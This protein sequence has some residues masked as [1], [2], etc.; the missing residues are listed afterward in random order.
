MVVFKSECPNRC[1]TCFK[2]IPASK[3]RLA[4]VCLKPW[5]L[6]GRRSL[7]STILISHFLGRVLGIGFLNSFSKMYL[8]FG[9]CFL[10]FFKILF[11][12]L[13]RLIS[14]LLLTVLVLPIS[15]PEI[16]LVIALFMS[17]VLSFQSLH[18]RAKI[19]PFRAPVKARR[20]NRVILSR[21]FV[22]ATSFKNF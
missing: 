3:Q 8:V 17:R 2:V 15:S 9:F 10:H 7:P 21:S 11:V 1:W 20:R 14:R 18:S 13:S 16:P 22:L 5:I 6:I 4:C 12:F 19:S